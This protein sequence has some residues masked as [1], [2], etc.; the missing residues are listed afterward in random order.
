MGEITLELRSA[1][2]PDSGLWGAVSSQ[3]AKCYNGE[4]LMAFRSFRFHS[5]ELS[6]GLA[7]VKTFM[8]KIL[9][10][11][12]ASHYAYVARDKLWSDFK[13]SGTHIF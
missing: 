11:K 4:H 3:E 8:L 2:I 9:D 12:P 6:P 5:T 1:R 7:R 10:P 13:E